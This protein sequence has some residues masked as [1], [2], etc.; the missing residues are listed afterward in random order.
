VE[1]SSSIGVGEERDC[2]L[3]GTMEER[4]PSAWK[5]RTCKVSDITRANM[6]VTAVINY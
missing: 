5:A 4:H 2:C 3:G 6:Q 1:S